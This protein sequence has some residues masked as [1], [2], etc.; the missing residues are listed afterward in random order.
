MGSTRSCQRDFKEGAFTVA[1]VPTEHRSSLTRKYSGPDH[2]RGY[3]S[4]GTKLVL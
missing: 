2:P 1:V 4:N 3:V